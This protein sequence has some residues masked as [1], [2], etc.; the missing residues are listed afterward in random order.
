MI[1]ICAKEIV[2]RRSSAGGEE[3]NDEVGRVNTAVRIHG[4]QRHNGK[5]ILC[6]S[7]LKV[8]EQ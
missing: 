8:Q 1:I 3:T 4:Y 7:N 6:K 2:L 5:P